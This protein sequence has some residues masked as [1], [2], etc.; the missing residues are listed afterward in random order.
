MDGPQTVHCADQPERYRS[1]SLL[2]VWSTVC[3]A[4]RDDSIIAFDYNLLMVKLKIIELS[5]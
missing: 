5:F 1:K 3:D 4:V 2:S